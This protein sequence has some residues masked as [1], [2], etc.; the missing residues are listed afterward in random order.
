MCEDVYVCACKSRYLLHVIQKV[1]MVVPSGG[2][3]DHEITAMLLFSLKH[4]FNTSEK[5]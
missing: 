2:G 5:N 1:L 3:T 4:A